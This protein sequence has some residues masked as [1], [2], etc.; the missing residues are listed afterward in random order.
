MLLDGFACATWRT[1]QSRGKSTLEIEP[2]EPLREQDR[3]TLARE[4]ER[5]LRFLAEP[6][7]TGEFE[8]L[9]G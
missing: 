5:L 3:D 7:G 1:V 8:I 6:Q 4:G 2:F 9:F